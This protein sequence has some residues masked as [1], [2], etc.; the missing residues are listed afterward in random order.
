MQG[1]GISGFG[2]FC[3]ELK[4]KGDTTLCRPIFIISDAFVKN[5][6]VKRERIHRLPETTAVEEVNH[7]LLAIR[8]SKALT[9]DMVF[10]GLRDTIKK[11][12]EYIDRGYELEIPFTFGT[13]FAKERRV[14]FEFSQSRLQEV[15]RKFTPFYSFFFGPFY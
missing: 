14:R 13:L 5:F 2:C 9:K 8:F 15:G 6:R 1:A 4:V 10:S 3:W 11:I 12:G 7:S